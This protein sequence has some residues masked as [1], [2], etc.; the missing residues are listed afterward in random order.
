MRCLSFTAKRLSTW[1]DWVSTI[2][3]NRVEQALWR[4]YDQRVT[5]MV[6]YGESL[7]LV[8]VE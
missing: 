1:P 7:S 4:L 5:R 3:I 6:N 2:T 8:V